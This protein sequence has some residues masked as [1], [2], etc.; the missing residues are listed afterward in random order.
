MKVWIV[1]RREQEENDSNI[2]AVFS[3]KEKG[4]EYLSQYK[5]GG[6]FKKTGE[7][8]WWENSV[9]G[10]SYLGHTW[11]E[12]YFYLLEECEVK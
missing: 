6:T 2:D 4:L 1:L 5:A 7:I 3:T 8:A 10:T 12:R 9:Q 11:T